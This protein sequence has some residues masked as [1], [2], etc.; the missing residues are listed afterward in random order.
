MT[1]KG[2]KNVENIGD[3]HSTIDEEQYKNLIEYLQVNN[4]E[5]FETTYLSG[6]RDLQA[7]EIEYNRQ[8]VKFHKR[9]APQL[10]I[11][12]LN[13]LDEIIDEAD[14]TRKN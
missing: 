7:I 3:F 9:K 12:T 2:I 13:K 11:N 4:F 5:T 1:Y 10:L 14:W 8:V 6:A